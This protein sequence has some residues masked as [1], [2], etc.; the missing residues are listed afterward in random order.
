VV[1]K[2]SKAYNKFHQLR[3]KRK[4]KSWM[5]TIL[6][7]HF[8]KWQRKKTRARLDEF[9]NG[10]DYLTEL[11]SASVQQNVAAVFDRIVEDCNT[12]IIDGRPG[13]GNAAK[14]FFEAFAN[15]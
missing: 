14:S 2:L 1:E 8:L 9:E 6:R 4:F 13:A 10:I 12:R 5:F 15:S 11:E 7:N 3:D